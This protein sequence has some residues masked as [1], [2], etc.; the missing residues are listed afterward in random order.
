MNKKQR[1]WRVR[2]PLS[3]VD[4][5]AMG[6]DRVSDPTSRG[7]DGWMPAGRQAGKGSELLKASRC[8]LLVLRFGLPLRSLL[9]A[10]PLDRGGGCSVGREDGNLGESR[11]LNAPLPTILRRHELPKT[12]RRQK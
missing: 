7:A 3:T 11:R 8:G 2:Q 10:D 5:T 12:A 9:A 1:G 4:C 6:C